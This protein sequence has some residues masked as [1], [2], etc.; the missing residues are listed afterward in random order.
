M[1]DEEEGLNAGV[2]VG[3]MGDFEE[4]IEMLFEANNVSGI[5]RKRTI[6][7]P[8]TVSLAPTKG[9][10]LLTPVN[11]AETNL[12]AASVS[13]TDGAEDCLAFSVL[14]R[15]CRPSLGALPLSTFVA[16]ESLSMVI[17]RLPDFKSTMKRSK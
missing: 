11:N 10:A 7:K 1:L 4:G 17:P 5:D 3:G 12:S 14:F 16:S 13:G 15:G 6:F 8:Y 2:E 9:A